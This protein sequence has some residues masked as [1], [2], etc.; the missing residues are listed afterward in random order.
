MEK[1]AKTVDVKFKDLRIA[2]QALNE[3]KLLDKAIKLVG[4]SKDQIL[5]DFMAVM[6]KVP[7]DEAGKFPGPKMALDFY[8]GV[9]DLQEKAK[10][11]VVPPK[12]EAE[13][14]PKKEKVGGAAKSAKEKKEKVDKGPGVIASILDI[15]KSAKPPGITKVEILDALVVAFPDREKE[16]MAKTVAVQLSGKNGCRMETEKGVTFKVTDGKFAIAK[17]E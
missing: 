13:A 14:K 17:G 6:E 16:K 8:N 5:T 7:D 3:S 1:T 4:I 11:E 2:V 9:L 12:P 15:I 10:E